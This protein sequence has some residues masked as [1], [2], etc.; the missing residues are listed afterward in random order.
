MGVWRRLRRW[1]AERYIR[2]VVGEI[3]N[4]PARRARA[5]GLG[6]YRCLCGATYEA[7][8]AKQ[9]AARHGADHSH[10]FTPKR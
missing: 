10:P 1:R 7:R 4:P 3:T 2:R 6:V 9:A 8:D 5:G